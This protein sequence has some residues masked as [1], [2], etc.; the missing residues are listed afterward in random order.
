LC[1]SGSV[2]RMQ[3]LFDPQCAATVRKDFRYAGTEYK[4]GDDFP[5][6]AIGVTDFELRG[7]WA[8]DLV[9]FDRARAASVHVDATVEDTRTKKQPKGARGA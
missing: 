8:A 3:N 9:I 1:F 7:L 5:H 4:S 2:I 6:K